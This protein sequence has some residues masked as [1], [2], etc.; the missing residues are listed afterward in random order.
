MMVTITTLPFSILTFRPILSYSEPLVPL[1]KMFSMVT[2]S[3]TVD[4]NNIA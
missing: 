3:Y 2:R 4:N 1:N